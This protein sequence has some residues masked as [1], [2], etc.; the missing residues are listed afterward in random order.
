MET[1]IGS[2]AEQGRLVLVGALVIIVTKLVMH[3]LE[4]FRR[5]PCAHLDADIV[6]GIDIPG[7]GMAHHVAPLGPG[8]LRAGPEGLG[9]GR[10]ADRR[11]EGLPRLDHFQRI[12]GFGLE[13]GREIDARILSLGRDQRIDRAPFLG[14][15]IAEQIGPD[16]S[17]FGLNRIA[18][19]GIERA[20]H[21]TM[22]FLI[23]R[24]HLIPQ[25]VGFLREIRG[26][27]VI[28]TPPQ[29]ADIGKSQFLRAFIGK[30][31]ELRIIG[32]H[33]G[34]NGMPAGPQ[35][36]QLFGITGIGHDLA[37]VVQ[38]DH[39]ALEFEFPF[40]I[41]RIEIGRQI[42]QFLRCPLP[43]RCG[44]CQ[45]DLEQMQFAP[46]PGIK[47]V[48]NRIE[49]RSLFGIFDRQFGDPG[50]RPRFEPLGVFGD[51]GRADPGSARGFLAESRELLFDFG[52]EAFGGFRRHRVLLR[53]LRRAG[54]EHQSRCAAC[55]HQA[56]AQYRPG[57]W[58][59]RHVFPPGRIWAFRPTCAFP[60]LKQ[61]TPATQ[62]AGRPSPRINFSARLP[63][64]LS[65]SCTR[66]HIIAAT[67]V[68]DMAGP[69]SGSIRGRN[70]KGSRGQ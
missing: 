18:I 62:G 63:G 57:V 70:F 46:G 4:I 19:A 54:G 69:A 17:G 6:F 53:C 45:A 55:E 47:P 52:D 2:A 23:E 38:S 68:S 12:I 66:S 1:V 16:R 15:H 24:L 14:P 42:R 10:K 48:G 30:A 37:G 44:E 41:G 27:H 26:R 49:T 33:G 20:A 64:G 34:R 8:N 11:E 58:N 7:R 59:V 65:T 32:A 13:T 43:A 29:I 21:I 28:A 61:I 36:L 9:Q 25:A 35:G 60:A 22:Q 5:H 50:N 39:L 56:L 51:I 31:H 40:G 67:C 3:G